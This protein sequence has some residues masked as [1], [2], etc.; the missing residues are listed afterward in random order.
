LEALQHQNDLEVDL[1]LVAPWPSSD[2]RSLDLWQEAVA[3]TPQ[4][5]LLGWN[6]ASKPHQGVHI[7]K[8]KCCQIRPVESHKTYRRY[9][10]R[11]KCKVVQHCLLPATTMSLAP[12]EAKVVA[13]SLE[14]QRSPGTS[15]WARA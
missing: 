13:S 4:T 2:Q 1:E 14:G 8:E 6:L 10:A 9:K 7:Q 12:L 3:A 11:W 15:L 5:I